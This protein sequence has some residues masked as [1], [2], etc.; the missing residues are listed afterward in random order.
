[1]IYKDGR[2][3]YYTDPVNDDFMVTPIK[4]YSK[5]DGEYN[6]IRKNIFVRFFD[7]FIY[8]CLAVPYFMLHF[9]FRG[10]KILGKENLREVKKK[11]YFVYCNHTQMLDAFLAA[12]VVFPKRVSCVSHKTA[13]SIGAGK[14]FT[15]ALGAIP[16]AE[17]VQGIKNMNEAMKFYIQK[18]KRAI[19][20]YPEAHMWSY[21]T[22]VREF[23]TASF[24]FAANTKSPVFPMAVT[25]EKRY[26]GFGKHKKE[27]KPRIIVNVGK[28]IYY[29]ENLS[30]KE[31]AVVMHDKTFE[32]MKEKCNSENNYAYYNYFQVSEDEIQKLIDKNK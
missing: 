5:I 17:T 16:V 23:P 7:W 14:V 29:N 19:I 6:Y 9:K 13:V 10:V 31:N 26:R 32:Y 25:Y 3:R 2:N 27:R 4:E 22:D 15:K 1:M 11:G 24:K 12:S 8:Y 30:S 20:I 21:F 28:P 18:Q